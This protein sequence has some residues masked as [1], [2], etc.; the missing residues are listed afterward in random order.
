M[1]GEKMKELTDEIG[2]ELDL[3]IDLFLRQ[4]NTLT[5]SASD[6]SKKHTA[7]ALGM[8]IMKFVRNIIETEVTQDDSPEPAYDI[9]RLR[10]GLALRTLVLRKTAI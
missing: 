4:Q 9:D 6:S 5:P 2:N 1:S 7:E 8:S 10:L 3:C